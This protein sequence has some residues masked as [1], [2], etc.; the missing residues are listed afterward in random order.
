MCASG[1]DSAS[2]TS[3]SSRFLKSIGLLSAP[4]VRTA[5]GQEI[6][7][8]KVVKACLPD[9]SSLA[10]EYTGKTC[11]GDFVK[12]TKDGVPHEVLI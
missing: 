12:G 10:P 11:I 5:E 7:P 9:P 3:T 8:L 1:W 6:I 4:P 2:T